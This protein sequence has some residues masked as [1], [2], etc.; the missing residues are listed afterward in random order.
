MSYIPLVICTIS[1]L[2]N[3][4][5]SQIFC[6][7]HHFHFAWISQAKNAFI[8]E[9][10]LFL[11]CH[12]TDSVKVKDESWVKIHWGTYY[13]L[14]QVI[15][16]QIEEDVI[17]QGYTYFSAISLFILGPA[18]RMLYRHSSYVKL[19]FELY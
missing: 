3:L 2:F 17:S 13:Q 1:H 7:R 14:G 19:S 5:Y 9:K 10:K 6:T 15:R 18:C 4:T 12:F 8:V 11:F 16:I